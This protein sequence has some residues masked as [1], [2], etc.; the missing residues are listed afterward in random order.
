M[1]AGSPRRLL[2]SRILR[3]ILLIFSAWTFLEA[4]YIHRNFVTGDT[5]PAPHS[6]GEKVFITGLAWNNEILLRTLLGNQIR[7][8]ALALGV[9]NVYISIYENGSYDGTKDALRDLHAMLE[10]MGVRNRITLD[11]TSHEDI[12]KGR[13]TSPKEGWIRIDESGHEK[14]G[15]NKGDYALRRI[16]YLASLRN[17]A[18]EPLW[19]LAQKGEIFDKILFLNDVVFSAD[20]VL[21]LLQTRDG[22]YATACALDFETPPS[23]YDTFAVRDSGG[24]LPAMQR[25]PYFRSS[26]SRDAVVANQPVPVQSCWNGIVAMSAAPFYNTASPLHFRGVPDTL[27]HQHVEGSECCLIHADNPLSSTLGNWINPNVRVGYC[28]PDLR[29]H[30]VKLEWDAFKNACERPYNAVHPGSGAGSWISHFQ[31]AWGLWENRVRR[32]VSFSS[33]QNWK[34]RRKMQAWRDEKDGNVEVGEMCLVDEMH[35]IE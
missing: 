23:F 13:P 18:L 25:W 4:L 35:V 21:N 5:T 15:I 17:K 9:G 33:M 11:E 14:V 34:V 29:N 6:T 30:K 32:W 16:H 24:D 28:H 10:A 3:I 20:D 8:V 26:A 19:E 22:K 31:I 1:L 27:A 12:V 7:D 2:R